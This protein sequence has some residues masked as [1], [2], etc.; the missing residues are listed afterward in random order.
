VIA[1]LVSLR[2][3]PDG[4]L[5]AGIYFSGGASNAGRVSLPSTSD[6]VE[7][8]LLHVDEQG[9]RLNANRRWLT[10]GHCRLFWTDFTELPFPRPG[11]MNEI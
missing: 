3:T 1:G 6:L 11:Y 2:A 7:C 8:R 9:I 4:R 5:A 10:V